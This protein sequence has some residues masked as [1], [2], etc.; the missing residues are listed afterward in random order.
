MRKAQDG[1]DPGPLQTPESPVVASGAREEGTGI[2]GGPS[3]LAA[4]AAA[5]ASG[6]AALY[7]HKAGLLLQNSAPHHLGQ[8]LRVAPLVGGHL[9]PGA[10]Q[11]PE[12]ML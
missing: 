10:G 11:P 3:G 12:H 2:S 7:P 5:A 9:H 4:A 1:E 8:L 6:A